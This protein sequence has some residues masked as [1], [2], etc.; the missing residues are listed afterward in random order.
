[1]NDKVVLASYPRSGN[2]F[3]RNILSRVYGQSSTADRKIGT[4]R[5][6]EASPHRFLKTHQREQ[7]FHHSFPA[8]PTVYLVRD[9]RDAVISG[10]H[11]RRDIVEPG[12]DFDLILRGSI[13]APRGSYFGGWSRNVGSWLPHAVLLVR[14][15]DLLVEPVAVVEQFRAFMDLPPAEPDRLP[16][17]EQMKQGNEDFLQE[18]PVLDQDGQ[19]HNRHQL[20]FRKGKAGSW[21][22]EMTEAQHRLFWQKHGYMMEALGYHKDGSRITRKELNNRFEELK[23]RPWPG[24]RR[25]FYWWF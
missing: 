1:M 20:F 6:F 25:L 18:R 23:K 24:Q 11:H 8:Y 13:R 3:L 12:V 22:E 19:T 17:F 7:N 5:A 16:T 10:A 15:E 4:R 21:K 9:G 2:T 14:Y